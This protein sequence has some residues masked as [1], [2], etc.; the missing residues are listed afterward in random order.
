MVNLSR[1]GSR[2]RN[3]R[4]HSGRLHESRL[5]ERC[6]SR[7][8]LLLPVVK[9]HLPPLPWR[10]QK[11]LSR[12]RTASAFCYLVG[13]DCPCGSAMSLQHLFQGCTALSQCACILVT[14][15]QTLSLRL[16]EFLKPHPE[17]GTEPMRI[18]TDTICNSDVLKRLF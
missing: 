4:I 8:W 18:L 17:L 12:L 7:G 16:E 1:W 6:E 11:V 15:R 13:L 3:R 9:C 5:R 2:C 14:Y 10:N